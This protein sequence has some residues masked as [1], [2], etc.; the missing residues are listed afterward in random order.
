MLVRGL[1]ALWLLIRGPGAP[2][3]QL[4]APA[5]PVCQLGTSGPLGR[6]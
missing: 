1:R 3:R 2:G 4:G 5:L 6:K